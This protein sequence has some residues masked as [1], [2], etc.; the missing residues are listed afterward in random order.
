MSADARVVLA[1]ATVL[2][3]D[4]KPAE[5]LAVLGPKPTGA[6]ATYLSALCQ[7]ATGSLLRSAYLL[8]GSAA[9]AEDLVQETFVRLY[10]K[11]H[12]VMVADAP[13]AYVRRSLV[14]G[15]LNQRRRASSREIVLD[16]LPE[17]H[18]GRDLDHEI[19][20]RDAVWRMLALL[21]A[22]QRAALVLRFFH[23]LPDEEIAATLQCRVGTVR[24]LVS[25]GLSALR[26]HSAG[27]DPAPATREGRPL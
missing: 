24:S 13:L 23:D 10:P 4:H 12:R 16:E 3:L 14:N 5:A 8:T 18:D 26:E 1:R 22:R 21:P 20:S 9:A 27:L 15:F 11:W 19:A 25:R 7:G 2:A 17:Q 6:A